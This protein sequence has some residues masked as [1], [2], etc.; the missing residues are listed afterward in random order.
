[1]GLMTVKELAVS[2]KLSEPRIRHYLGLPGAPLPVVQHQAV[3][4]GRKPGKY[5]ESAITEFIA[6]NKKKPGRTNWNEVDYWRAR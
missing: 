2:L 1:V 4:Q 6:Q 5:D 3:Y